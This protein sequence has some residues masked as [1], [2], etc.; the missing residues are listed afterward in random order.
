LSLER[1][2]FTMVT[3]QREETETRI[4]VTEAGTHYLLYRA[5]LRE[6]VLLLRN[7]ATYPET[8][9]MALL[10]RVRSALDNGTGCDNGSGSSEDP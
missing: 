5:L 8:E 1:R 3:M 7:P 9:R 4:V 2:L 6:T 10:Q